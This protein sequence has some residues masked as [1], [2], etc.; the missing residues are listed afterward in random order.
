MSTTTYA[1]KTFTNVELNEEDLVL[2]KAQLNKDYAQRLEA[3]Y[4]RVYDERPEDMTET[5]REIY[6][7]M[8][9]IFNLS[10]PMATPDELVLKQSVAFKYIENFIDGFRIGNKY[11]PALLA[12]CKYVRHKEI[13]AIMTYRECLGQRF[14]EDMFPK[15]LSRA[16]RVNK[17]NLGKEL[18]ELRDRMV[19][20]IL[21]HCKKLLDT[22]EADKYYPWKPLT[23]EDLHA[24]SEAPLF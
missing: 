1:G 8:E 5:T 22:I 7:I 20:E 6:A 23:M 14:L 19:S 11:F 3:L 10:M 12:V 13:S 17:P 2:L 21:N 16:L 9:G 15:A 4:L 18:D 24:L